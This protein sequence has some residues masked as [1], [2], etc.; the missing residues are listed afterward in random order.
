MTT[1]TSTRIVDLKR[2][3]EIGPDAVLLLR[4]M[5][6][7]ND[8]ALANWGLR[9][10]KEE[11][12]PARRHS[13]LGKQ[14]YFVRLQCGHLSEALSLAAEVQRSS[15]LHGFLLSRCSQDAKDAFLRILEFVRG[16]CRRQEFERY[17]VSVRDKITFHYDPAP[18]RAALDHRADHDATRYSKVTDGTD[19]DR[20]RFD[21]ADDL[22]DS[23]VCRQLWGI[24][25]H[26]DLRTEADRIA[27]FGS[28]RCIDYL[29]FSCI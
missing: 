14:R 9:H 19:I 25:M 10:F 15:R 1:G 11:Q 13:Q 17:I 24:P 8:I 26:A 28:D 2:L 3:R 5:R 20:W 22:E 6:A 7:A 18:T 12:P 4:L 27:D 29:T 21:I 23:I 16:G